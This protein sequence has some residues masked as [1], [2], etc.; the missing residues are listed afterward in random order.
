MVMCCSNAADTHRCKLLV[1]GKNLHHGVFKGMTQ[2][3]VNY[4]A[5]KNGWVTT[6]LTLDWFENCFVHEAKEGITLARFVDL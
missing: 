5:N 2:L 3:P 6:E 1:I 4:C